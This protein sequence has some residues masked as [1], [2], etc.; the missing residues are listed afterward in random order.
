MDALLCHFCHGLPFPCS[1][2]QITSNALDEGACLTLQHFAVIRRQQKD[3]E[4]ERRKAGL[5]RRYA[6]LAAHPYLNRTAARLER[7]ARDSQTGK[8][9]E[10]A[11]F[12]LASAHDVTMAPLLSALGLE[13]AGFPKFAARLVFELWRSPEDKDRKNDRKR[14]KWLDNMFI[15]VLYNG[16][17]LTFDTAFCRE[18]N[19]RSAQPLCPL[20][21]FLSFVRKDMFNIVNATSYQQACHQIVL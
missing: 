8:G 3:D 6:V 9:K 7:I 1:S 17:D 10:E 12:A 2:T 20:G 16:E 4:L 21:N 15:R 19:R 18:H 5:Y 11:V 13:G 14:G